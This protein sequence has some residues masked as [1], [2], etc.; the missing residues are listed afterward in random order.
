[1]G[2]STILIE[3][4][5]YPNDYQREAVRKYLFMAL[6]QGLYSIAKGVDFIAHH[7]SYFDIPENDQK[8]YDV[9]LRS[10]QQED[11]TTIDIAYQYHYKMEKNQLKRFLKEMERG[12]LKSKMGHCEIQ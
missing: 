6:L 9:I 5:H 3:A 10:I 7:K 1:M 2:Y 4:G 8:F 12:N 11:G